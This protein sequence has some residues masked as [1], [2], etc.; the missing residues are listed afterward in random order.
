MSGT[1]GFWRR[2]V[3]VWLAGVLGVTSMLVQ[4]LPATLLELPALQHLSPLLLRLLVLAN[5]LVLVTLLALLG[6]GVAHRV[7]LGSRLAGTAAA[8][9][10]PWVLWSLLVGLALGAAITLLDRLVAPLLGEAWQAVAQRHEPVP[11]WRALVIGTLYGGLAEEVML[12][13]GVMSA[14]AWLLARA[15]GAR[16]AVFVLAALLAALVFGAAHLPALAQEVA[17]TPAIVAR[18]VALNMLAGFAYGLLFWRRGLEAA[19]LAHAATHLGFAL[20]RI[21]T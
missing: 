4:P 17:L 2:F 5:P 8:G 21:A 16:P 12:R 3:P 9:G 13:W 19:M 14:L 1:P 7:G 6:A 18:T 11:A 20:A 15:W 10:R